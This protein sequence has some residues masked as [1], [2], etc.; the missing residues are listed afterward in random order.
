MT[1]LAYLNLD[2]NQ[3]AALPPDLSNV[4]ALR[5][6]RLNGNKLAALPAEM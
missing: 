6:L 1:A 5:W 3:L 4:T 2:N